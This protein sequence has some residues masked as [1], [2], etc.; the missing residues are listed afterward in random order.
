MSHRSEFCSGLRNVPRMADTD[1]RV[2][3]K[4]PFTSAASLCE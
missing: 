2:P 1:R 3:A 4:K